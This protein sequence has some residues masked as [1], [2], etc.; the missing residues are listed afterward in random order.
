MGGIVQE[1][2]LFRRL[3][4]GAAVIPIVSTGGATL[5]VA[6]RIGALPADL[7]DEFDYV[8]LLHHHL[9]IS[10][11]EERFGSPDEQPAAEGERFWRPRARD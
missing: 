8:A 6:G 2:E 11:R 4:P 10:V 5:E 7:A 9:G 1:Y 3:Q